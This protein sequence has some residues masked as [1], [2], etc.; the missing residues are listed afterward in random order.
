MKAVFLDTSFVVASVNKSDQLH[1]K[2]KTFALLYDEQP[3]VTTS[4]ILLEVGN[5]LARRDKARAAEVIRSFIESKEIKVIYVDEDLLR[6]AFDLYAKYTDKTWGL[7]DCVS[8]IVMR[9]EGVTDA[10][11]ADVDFVQAGF[12]A[13]LRS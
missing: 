8:F 12:N 5:S 10:L 3:V 1:E 9:R 11:T 7:V 4:A 13:L 6:E 2:A